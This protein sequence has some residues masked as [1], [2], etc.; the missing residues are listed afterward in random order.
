MNI[1]FYSQYININFDE[2]LIENDNELVTSQRVYLDFKREYF[3]KSMINYNNFKKYS[4][5]LEEMQDDNNQVQQVGTRYTYIWKDRNLIEQK[6]K[7]I[8]NI[9]IE[10][11][12]LLNN[13]HHYIT[14]LNANPQ[15]FVQKDNQVKDK[16]KI[17]NDKRSFLSKLFDKKN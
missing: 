3:D 15:A 12:R 2:I 8:K 7:Q 5:E 4:S 1:D 16:D 17:V 6:R 13:F 14:L 9:V 10:Q 11:E